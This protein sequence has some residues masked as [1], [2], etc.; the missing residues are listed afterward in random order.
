M[1]TSLTTHELNAEI[2]CKYHPPE[3]ESIDMDAGWKRKHGVTRNLNF[4][5]LPWMRNLSMHRN[6]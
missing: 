2:L 4:K 1:A 5:W 3:A 6:P